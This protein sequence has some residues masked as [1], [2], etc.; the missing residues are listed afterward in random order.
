MFVASM[1]ASS[2]VLLNG[3]PSSKIPHLRVVRQGDSLSPLLFILESDRLTSLPPTYGCSHE[4]RT[5]HSHPTATR[6][7]PATLRQPNPSSGPLSP[8]KNKK[9]PCFSNDGIPGGLPLLRRRC[10]RRLPRGSPSSSSRD[11][12]ARERQQNQS[13]IV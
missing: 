3:V 7:R 13:Q 12:E 9:F 6:G 11:F 5:V 1:T 2:R 8:R 10:R 4:N